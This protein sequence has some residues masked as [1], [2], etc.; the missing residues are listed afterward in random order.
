MN[1][2][3]LLK[4]LYSVLPNQVP[5]R[6][7]KRDSHVDKITLLNKEIYD[8]TNPFERK[9]ITFNSIEEGFLSNVGNTFSEGFRKIY[10]ADEPDAYEILFVYK[11][12]I[13]LNDSHLYYHLC[14]CGN[15][16]RIKPANFSKYFAATSR[17][18]GFF[19][20]AHMD[21]N[22]KWLPSK[23]ERLPVCNEC[24]YTMQLWK[25][26]FRRDKRYGNTISFNFDIS[27]FYFEQLNAEYDSPNEFKKVD[28]KSLSD[29]YVYNWKKIRQFTLELYNFTCNRCKAKMADNIEEYKQNARKDPS[30]HL[31]VHHKDRNKR[32]NSIE[33]LEVLCVNCHDKEHPNRP[34]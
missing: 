26:K 29:S 14:W 8:D 23:L 31:E 1:I 30:K 22:G 28:D 34:K 6:I 10:N 3:T 4:G 19:D 2:N 5:P 9:P 16:A 33:N 7:L 20:I 24:F 13:F 18:D 27:R 32:N 12:N 17:H 21:E 15:L 25:R 11:K